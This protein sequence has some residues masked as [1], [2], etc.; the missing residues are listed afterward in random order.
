[1]LISHS[2]IFIIVMIICYILVIE[3]VYCIDYF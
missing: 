1:M 3:N 2:G